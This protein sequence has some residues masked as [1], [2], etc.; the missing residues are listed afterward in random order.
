MGRNDQTGSDEFV[1]E[2]TPVLQQPDY[3][4]EERPGTWWECLLFGWQHTLV[5]IS[6][7]A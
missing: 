5:D 6:P 1:W 4:I 7:C 3:G 2:E